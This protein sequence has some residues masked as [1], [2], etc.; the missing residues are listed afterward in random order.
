MIEVKNLTKKFDSY[1]ALDDLSLSV[2]KGSIYGL[3]GPNGAGKTTLMKTIMGI[4]KADAGEILIDGENVYENVSL[5]DNTIYIS[6]EL[7]FFNNFSIKQMSELYKGVYSNWSDE[8]FNKLKEVFDIDIKRNVDRLSK[9]MKK[10]VAFWLALSARPNLLIL[11]EPLDG[12]DPVMRRKVLNLMMQDVAD[13]NLTVMISSHNL[14][15]LEDI[16]D[17]VGI[18]NKGKLMLQRKLDDMKS[19]THKIQIAFKGGVFPEEFANKFKILHKSQLGQVYSIIL[20]G[21][22]NKIESELN[23]YN[24]IIMDMIPL[25]LEEIFIYELGGEGYEIKEIIL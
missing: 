6:D 3:V 16:C 17:H 1:A 13:N 25:T 15:E 5:K 10:Q 19:E 14:R 18:M 2:E 22:K 21:D 8:R 4:Y 12:L 7:Y 23:K 24:P 20:N 9:G 11:D